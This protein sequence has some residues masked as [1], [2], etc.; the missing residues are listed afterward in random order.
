M[1][2][3]L[4]LDLNDDI[5]KVLHYFSYEHFYVIYCRFWDLD[6]GARGLRRSCGH[7]GARR[8]GRGG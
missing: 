4:E 3:L 7:P 2:A 8:G 1:A 6:T 5:N